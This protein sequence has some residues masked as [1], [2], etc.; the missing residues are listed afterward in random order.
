MAPFTFKKIIIVIGEVWFFGLGGL[1]HGERGARTYNG[2]L[3]AVPPVERGP[4]PP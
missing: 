4:G 1:R 3:G 2:G